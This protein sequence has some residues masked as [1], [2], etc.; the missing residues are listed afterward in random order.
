M[1][2]HQ[3]S[4]YVDLSCLLSVC[5]V[6]VVNLF[7]HVVPMVVDLCCDKTLSVILLQRR[8]RLNQECE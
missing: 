5:F 6:G 3:V 8:K 2:R 4:E 7:Y 1:R